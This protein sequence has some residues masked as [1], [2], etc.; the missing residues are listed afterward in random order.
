LIRGDAAIAVK[1]RLVEAGA[2]E[3][4]L[5]CGIERKRRFC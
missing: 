5:A 2:I 1:S 3:A 4:T